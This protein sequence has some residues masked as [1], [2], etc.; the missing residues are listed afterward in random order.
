MRPDPAPN[1]TGPTAPDLTPRRLHQDRAA[2][3]WLRGGLLVGLPAGVLTA[4]LLTA[5]SLP[6]ATVSAVVILI[7]ASGA[8]FLLQAPV[9]AGLSAV[10]T[11]APTAPGAAL[12]LLRRLNRRRGLA[13]PLRHALYHAAATLAHRRGTPADRAAAAALAAELL[14]H[15]PEPDT[16]N[17]AAAVQ[18]AP[19]RAALLLILADG[20]LAAGRPQA[21]FPALAALAHTAVTLDQGLERLVLHTRYALAM[22]HHAAAL[23]HAKAKAD[24]GALM[25]AIACRRLHRDLLTAAQYTGDPAAAWLAPRVALLG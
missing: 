12:T 4:G 8:L 3:R 13:P 1:E 7:A 15:G 25:P 19:P 21:A 14:N 16:S 5:W 9:V 17:P 2:D 6:V 22:G 18:T 24:L 23:D 20:H 11:L 10:A